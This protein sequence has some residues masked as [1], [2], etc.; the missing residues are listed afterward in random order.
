MSYFLGLDV[1][2][3]ATKAVLLDRSGAVLAVA[4]REYDF[5]TPR[6]LWAEQDTEAARAVI[7][8]VTNLAGITPKERDW[9]HALKT[10]YGDGD[11]LAHPA[12]TA[13][14]RVVPL[15]EIDARPPG[16]AHADS[17]DPI[18]IALQPGNQAPALRSRTD[19]GGERQDHRQD[20]VDRAL[21]EDHH[22]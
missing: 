7:A 17:A 15:L 20:L 10:L 6:P 8:K 5:Q 14:H 3:T 4:A 12:D 21:V 2:T 1:S 16:E 18:E 13:D 9:W 22:V 11:K 19:H